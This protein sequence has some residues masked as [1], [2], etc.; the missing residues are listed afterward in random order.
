MSN[1]EKIFI[2]KSIDGMED[3][4]NKLELDI[5]NLISNGNLEGYLKLLKKEEIE[6][7]ELDLEVNDNL[8]DNIYG[9]IKSRHFKFSNKIK[10]S[11]YFDNEYVRKGENLLVF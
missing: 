5:E 10:N 9:L 11:F 8:S 6:P 4:I 3:K 1:Q 2:P 7:D